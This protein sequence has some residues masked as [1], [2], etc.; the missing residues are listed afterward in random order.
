M[1]IAYSGNFLGEGLRRLGQDVVDIR[2]SPDTSLD[3]ILDAQD[4][5][6]DIVLI[7]LWGNTSLPLKMH[8]CRRR[9]VAYAVDSCLNEFWQAPLLSLFDDVFFDQLLTAPRL[10]RLGLRAGW[11][12]LCASEEDF[13]EPQEKLYDISFV[14]RVTE[15]RPK[16]RNLLNLIAGEF[17]LNRVEGVSRAR[18]QDIHAQSRIVLNENFFNG[19]NLRALQGFASGSLLLTE[20]GGVGMDRFFT[21]GRHYASFTPD[22]VLDRIAD[23]LGHQGEWAAAAAAGRDACRERHTSR[24]RAGDLLRMVA[25]NAARNSRRPDSARKLAEAEAKHAYARRFG[26]SFEEA[27]MLA[28]EAAQDHGETGRKAD[29]LL[30]LMLA[31]SGRPGPA[32]K[33]F[34]RALKGKRPM[35]PAAALAMSLLHEGGVRRV[36]EGL[37]PAAAYF[38]KGL[39]DVLE[40]RN[41]EK[42]EEAVFGALMLELA[43]IYLELGRASDLGFVKIEKERFP[44]YALEFAML[45]WDRQ[46]SKPALDMIRRC[47]ESCGA[48]LGLPPLFAAAVEKGIASREDIAYAADLARLCYDRERAAALRRALETPGAQ[49]QE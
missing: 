9:L 17:S 43:R 20:A 44:D 31:R 33:R 32:R 39:L 47:A 16:R 24:A 28:A 21:D 29:H 38:P 1:R 40:R 49:A 19:L 18:M 48:A 13:R 23:I 42:S 12:P 36:C 41:S 22:N 14:G 10:K 11:L 2:L 6:P 45:A 27:V 46:P 8:A 15:H 3:D 7:E 37:K 5:A 35:L 30:G 34:I 26:G 25:D 4:P